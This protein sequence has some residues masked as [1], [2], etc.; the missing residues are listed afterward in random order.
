M[1][2]HHRFGKLFTAP[3]VLFAALCWATAASAAI[4]V[5]DTWRDGNRNQPDA[6]TNSIPYAENNGVTGTDADSDLDLESRWCRGGAGTL[7]PV[8]VGGGV[9]NLRGTLLPPPSTSSASWTTYFTNQ[10]GNEVKLAQVGDKLYLTW[11]FKLADVNLSNGSQAFRLAVVD[12]PARLAADGSPA[13]GVYTGY[14]LFGNMGQT[15]GHSRPWDL[16]TRNAPSAELLSASGAW[17]SAGVQDGTNGAAG[18]ANGVQYTFTLMAERLVDDD[19]RVSMRLDGDGLNGGAG[20]LESVYTDANPASFN[21]DTFSLR[22]GRGDQT[23]LTFDT[24]LL[25]VEYKPIPEPAS[26]ALL[27][28]GGV[29][30]LAMRRRD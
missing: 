15:F 11:V 18:Y 1:L 24:S 16:M 8:D 21:F 19:L 10:E 17:T 4:I 7:D 22:P 30:L 13:A 25:R 29:A 2:L 27:A 20:F 26:L 5:N 14:G 9:F 3:A 23:A 12:S 28:L 6:P